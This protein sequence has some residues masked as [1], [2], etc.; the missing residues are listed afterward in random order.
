[1]LL[2]SQRRASRRLFFQPVGQRGPSD[3]KKATHPPLGVTLLYGGEHPTLELV[4]VGRGARVPT[5]RSIA[6]VALV[7][8]VAA[9]DALARLRPGATRI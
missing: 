3:A 7:A 4:G 2:W 5:E 9:S 8:L 6:I 1:M